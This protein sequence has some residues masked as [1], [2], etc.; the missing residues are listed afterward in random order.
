[1]IYVHIIM[2]FVGAIL[3]GGSLMLGMLQ[4]IILYIEKRLGSVQCQDIKY[5]ESERDFFKSSFSC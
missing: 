1:M 4:V 3:M 5:F 2:F